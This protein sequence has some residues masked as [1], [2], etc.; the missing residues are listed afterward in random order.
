MVC[1]DIVTMPC[2]NCDSVP[3]VRTVKQLTISM[4]EVFFECSNEQCQYQWIAYLS[5]SRTLSP[6]ATPNKKVI[7]N[8]HW[9]DALEGTP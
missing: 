3:K 6:S 7:R 4:R 1:Q 8:G 5:F 9:R 2:P